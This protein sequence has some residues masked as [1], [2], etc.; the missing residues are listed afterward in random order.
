MRSRVVLSPKTPTAQNRRQFSYYYKEKYSFPVVLFIS[1]VKSVRTKAHE[2]NYLHY[3]ELQKPY[4]RIKC[5]K[6]RVVLKGL[7]FRNDNFSITGCFLWFRVFGL[8][9]YV[10]NFYEFMADFTG[11]GVTVDKLYYEFTEDRIV[12]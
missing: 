12:C 8:L 10:I 9:F 6:Y 2:Y 5:E 3:N 4:L 1:I 11:K 7:L